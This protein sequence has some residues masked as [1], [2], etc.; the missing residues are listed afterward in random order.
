[1]HY[2]DCGS[3]LNKCLKKLR[4]DVN[5]PTIFSPVAAAAL[6]DDA[7]SIVTGPEPRADWPGVPVTLVA[8]GIWL[9]IVATTGVDGDTIVLVVAGLVT[10]TFWTTGAGWSTVDVC[11]LLPTNVLVFSIQWNL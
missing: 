10:T 1:M 11:S 2:D 8:L 9:V 5:G 3:G 6:A 4:I 7:G